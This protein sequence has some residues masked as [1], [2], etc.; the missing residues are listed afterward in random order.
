LRHGILAGVAS[1]HHAY[2]LL[3]CFLTDA[4][5]EPRDLVAARGHD[6]VRDQFAGRDAA[7]T[8]NHDRHA[9]KLEE[10]LRGFRAHTRS[11]TCGG[12]N[13]GYAAHFIKGESTAG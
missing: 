6:N 10:L 9:I 7:Q 3:E 8:Q 5:F 12:K 11:E 2:L 4:L 1:A 13:G